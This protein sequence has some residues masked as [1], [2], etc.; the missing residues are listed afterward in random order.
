GEMPPLNAPSPEPDAREKFTQ[1]AEASMRAQICAGGLVPGPARVRRLNREE[2]TATVQY[3]LDIHMD[4]GQGLPAD[5][6][7]GEGFDNAA[8]ALVLSP[9]HAEKYMEA[10]KLA[11]DFA[12][13]EFKS[14][15][16]L[17]VA[18][19]GPGTTE[20]Q[21]AHDILHAFL[22]RAFRRPITEA[23]I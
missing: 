19:P 14:R 3:L 15:R 4:V 5:G 11:M 13:K 10:A 2:Y 22:P 23:Q 20:A 12:S 6:A 17:L 18:K 9:I 16:L 21:A 8:E 1:M 7:G